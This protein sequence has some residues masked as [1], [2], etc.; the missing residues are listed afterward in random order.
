MKRP[1][2]YAEMTPSGKKEVLKRAL[3]YLLMIKARW[4]EYEAD[5]EQWYRSGQGKFKG[6]RYPECFHGTSNWTDYDNICWGCEDSFT[7]YNPLSFYRW[8]FNRAWS[9]YREMGKRSEWFCSAPAD[10]FA[11]PDLYLQIIDWCMEPMREVVE[12]RG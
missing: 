6:Y 1:K 9:D 12:N 11:N 7:G 2:T 8:A 5:V 10:L 3:Q 4:A